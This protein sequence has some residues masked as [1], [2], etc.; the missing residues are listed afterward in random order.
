M[1][2]SMI[3]M[4]NYSI[5][6]KNIDRIIK[7]MEEEVERWRDPVVTKVKKEGGDPF[8]VLVSTVLSA[9]T[10]DSVT[11][12]VV[13]R[14]FKK[15][16]GPKDLADMKLEDIQELIKPVGFYRNKSKNLKKLA[17]VLISQYGGRVPDDMDSL[18]KLPG[19]GRKTANLVLIESFN[20][21]AICVDTHVHRISNRIGLVN[22][23]TPEETEKKLREILPRKYWKRYN[24]LLV[25]YGQ[26]LCRPVKPLCNECRI[27][28]LCYFYKTKGGK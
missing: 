24:K 4:I 7:I 12:K 26:N 10:R 15:I 27:R 17:Q 2:I 23:K 20:K 16:K 5:S 1:N 6:L 8:K 18:L 3:P 25:M 9:R 11:E 21:D 28:D 13:E 19:V 22:T 14:L